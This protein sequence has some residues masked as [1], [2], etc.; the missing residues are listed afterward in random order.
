MKHIAFL[1]TVISVLG[2]I[3][4]LP[5]STR[6]A[7]AA[8]IDQS[9]RAAL[10][11]LYASIPA[12]QIVAKK[13]RAVLVFPRILKGG[14]LVAAQHSDGA[15]IANGK[16]VAYYNTV[17]ASYGLQAGIQKFGY[18]LFFMNDASMAYLQNARGWELG[19]APSLVVVDTGMARSLSTTTL[20]KGVYVFFFSQKGLMG[21]LGLQGTKITRYTPSE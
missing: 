6:A 1:V 17:A 2:V 4:F 10:N 5:N 21:G 12:A 8:Q 20:R 16:T 15:L 19:T 11:S 3:T 7:S 13:A 9:A 18:A 14:F